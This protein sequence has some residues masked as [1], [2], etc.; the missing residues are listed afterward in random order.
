MRNQNWIFAITLEGC[1]WCSVYVNS[2]E[3]NIFKLL[4]LHL[5]LLPPVDIVYV[6]QMY[7]VTVNFRLIEYVTEII[8]IFSYYMFINVW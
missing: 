6:K 7:C 4:S 8:Q 5:L 3:Y 1:K 2:N